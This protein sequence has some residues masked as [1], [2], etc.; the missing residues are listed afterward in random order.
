MTTREIGNK[1][2]ELTCEY[3]KNNNYDI[4]KRNYT[5]KGGEVDIIA[6]KGEIIAF[7]EV[8]TR[9]NNAIVNGYE[10]ITKAKKN[11][12]F[13]TAQHY[14]INSG[15]DFQPRFDVAIVEKDSNGNFSLDYIE[16]AFDMS[17]SNIYF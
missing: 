2:E 1:G 11:R 7:V 6:S 13:K 3:L 9:S 5:I 16:N 17:D 12:I 14:F 8:K 10:A 15:V 4:V